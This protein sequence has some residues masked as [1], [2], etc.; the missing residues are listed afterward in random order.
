MIS[1]RRSIA[2]TAIVALLLGAGCIAPQRPD[3]VVVLASGADLESANPLVTTH[4]LSRQV[5]RFVLFVTL[6]RYDSAL[7]PQPYYAR[8]WQW[9]DGG[10]TLTLALASDLRWHDGVPTT[11]DDAVF[12]LLTARDPATGFPR[13]AELRSLDTAIAL[14]D[15]TLQLRFRSAPHA[16]PALLAELPIVPRHLL[17][18]VSHARMR[19]AEFNDAPV[20]NGPFRFVSRRRGSRW[21]FSRNDAFPSSLG[22]PPALRGV[23]IAVVDEATTK[24]AG[25]TSGE[26]DVA[27]ISPTMAALAKRDATLRVVSYPVL[28]GNA[29]FFNTT[30]TPFDDARVRRAV[31]RSID[32]RR[33]V[34]VALAGYGRPAATPV[35]PDSPLSW[36]EAPERDT[37]GADSLLDAA[38]WRR[39]GDGIRQRGGRRFEIELL[40]VG[41][42]DNVAEQLV[43]AD[44]AAR[45]IAVHLRQ[46]EM[47]TFL[48]TARA[49]Q[50]R[51][52]VLLAGVPGDLA[53]SYIS[54]LFLTSQRGGTLD[55]TGFHAPGLDAVLT[56][57]IDAPIGAPAHAAWER[58]QR[59]IDSLAPA[60]WLYHSR[61]VQGMTRRLRGVTM[62]LRGELVSVHDWS[63]SPR[64][65]RA[66]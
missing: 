39:S 59:A 63:L 13:A 7:V 55:Y 65:L 52:D 53:M 48:T 11:A 35:P 43:Q 10:R 34:E 15:T 32:R 46:T 14:D 33:I 28:F 1:H 12:T 6:V 27:G 36:R 47:G 26:L 64:S 66:P 49:S 9:S 57:A 45:G 51:F 19:G 60:T 37:L 62:D 16:L 42:G 56:S 50:K 24:F 2:S 18:A 23:V 20:G 40:S 4:P 54:A 31:A 30:R 21:S 8:R 58:V 61:G 5:Q 41:S 29:L 38:G 22:G 3:D 25:L 44:L 17:G